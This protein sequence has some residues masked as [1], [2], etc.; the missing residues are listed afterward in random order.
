L[1]TWENNDFIFILY[2]LKKE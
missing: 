2:F 1:G